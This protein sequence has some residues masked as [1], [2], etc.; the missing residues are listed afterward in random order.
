M[1]WLQWSLL[2]IYSVALALLFIYSLHRHLMVR[3]YYKNEKNRSLPGGRLDSYPRV[4]VQLPVY[5]EL[6]VVERLIRSTAEIEYP[7]DRLEIQVL[8]DSTDETT[9]IAQRCV[10]ELRKEGYDISCLHRDRRIGF[11]AGALEEGMRVAKGEYVALFDADFVPSPEFLLKTLP[12]FSDEGVGMVQARWEHLNRDYSLLTRIQAILLDGHFVMEHGARSRSGMFFNFNGTAGIWRRR[13]IEDAGGWQHDTL[14]EDLDLSYRAQLA[15]WRFI[16]LQ[17][18][19]CPAE[20]PVEMNAWKSQ[21][22][23]W[24]KGSMET[25]IKLLPR[26]I[27]SEFP[28]RVKLEAVIHLLANF[29]YVLMAIVA[30]LIFPAVLSRQDLGWYRVLVVDLPLFLAAAG[31][32]SR[33]Y[34][35]SQKELYRDWKSRLKYLPCVLAFGMGIALNN[36]RAV[37]EA[38]AGHK[39]EFRRTPKYRVVDRG[40]TW[41]DKRYTLGKQHLFSMFE[42]AI[43]VYFCWI[44]GYSL[45]HGVYFPIPFLMLFGFGFFYV[46]SASLLQQRFERWRMETRRK[47]C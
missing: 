15:G 14:T 23:R 1:L 12:H 26:M 41:W 9:Q 37:V 46:G 4:T 3:L 20:V 36:A 28:W 33:F 35:C 8:D 24:A 32:V 38:L 6:Y 29:S 45:L 17:D 5:N 10:D 7:R 43:G 22:F 25:A 27:R 18:L 47:R 13:C 21:Q 31:V 30:L 42:V 11:K 40:D 16:F 19:A 44:I 2:I 39:T 34:I